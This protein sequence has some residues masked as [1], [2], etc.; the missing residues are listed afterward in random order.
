M[1]VWIARDM[2]GELA[3]FPICP[4]PCDVGAFEPDVIWT[5]TRG[6]EEL[7][8]NLYPEITFENSPKKVTL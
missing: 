1:E 2:C 3:M 6:G 7:N 8:P 4:T 5:S